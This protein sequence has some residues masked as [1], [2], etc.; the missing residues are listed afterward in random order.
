MDSL[1]KKIMALLRY[2]GWGR[3]TLAGLC[4]TLC[5]SLPAAPAAPLPPGRFLLLMDTS[6]SMRARAD[7][8]A[9]T[10]ESLLAADLDGRLRPGDTMGMWT[11][12]QQVYHGRFPLQTWSPAQRDAVTARVLE[13]IR[14]QRY[15]NKA[16]LDQVITRVLPLVRDSELIT[17]ILLTDGS[18]PVHGTPFDENINNSFQTLRREQRRARMPFIVILRAENGRFVNHVVGQ[19]PWRF[20]IP[21]L[22]REEAALASATTPEPKSPQPAPHPTPPA[23]TA[24]A[25]AHP[26]P[27]PSPEP[28][29]ASTSHPP[30]TESVA[31]PVERSKPLELPEQPKPPE[32]LAL[33]E[34]AAAPPPAKPTVT[35]ETPATPTVPVATVMPAPQKPEVSPPPVS[36][37]AE[38]PV[39]IT[40]ARPTEPP[41]TVT[42][43]PPVV[44]DVPPLLPVPPPA[45]PAAADVAPP[46]EAPPV[47]LEP[48]KVE[49]PD[50]TTQPATQP[51]IQRPPEIE[52]IPAVG[53]TTDLSV[54]PEK[55]PAVRSETTP[56]TTDQPPA[57]SPAVPPSPGPAE[58]TQAG[59]S[60]V[61]LPV[62]SAVATPAPPTMRG[63][64]LLILGLL[65]LG[66]AAVLLIVLLRRARGHSTGSLIT[67]SFSRDRDR[68]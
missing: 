65:L 42:P 50:S 17:L 44:G 4:L 63:V 18:V 53:A 46:R 66:V 8:V 37:P 22:P 43:P 67:Q 5:G 26:V 40:E 11:F 28:V 64:T 54:P 62:Q 3:L 23:K 10:L 58:A 12:N 59:P 60:S 21:L 34:S 38:P 7:G 32:Q 14:E 16:D 20:S 51:V 49:P 1:E 13:F 48:V 9:Q 19:P 36:P 25:V 27:A 68:S 61:D 39:V 24:P 6:F 57:A 52:S 35:P 30:P 31:Q 55:P 41:P 15:E 2:F 29:I 33:R 45:S 47:A 56:P